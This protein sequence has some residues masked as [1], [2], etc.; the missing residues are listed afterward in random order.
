MRFLTFTGSWAFAMLIVPWATSTLSPLA[1]YISSKEVCANHHVLGADSMLVWSKCP[2]CHLG[3]RK[4]STN[5]LGRLASAQLSAEYPGI[6][7]RQKLRI[8]KLKS[9]GDRPK[10][11]ENYLTLHLC[12]D[13][14][15]S[16][17]ARLACT[18]SLDVLCCKLTKV[19]Q[20]VNC[21]TSQCQFI[22]A[23]NVFV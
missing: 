1:L 15:M 22:C 21:M 17:R 19:I 23:N 8:S 16:A 5:Y 13:W 18:F 6:V 10:V 20:Y 2:S 9:L 12:E 7:T 3:K 4:T 14:V 11:D